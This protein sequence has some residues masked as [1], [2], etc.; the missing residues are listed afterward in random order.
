[1]S[2]VFVDTSIWY[3]LADAAHFRQEGFQ[4]LP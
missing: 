3:E 4:T 2:R 1:V